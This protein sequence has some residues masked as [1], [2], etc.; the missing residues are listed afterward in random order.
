MWLALQSNKTYSSKNVKF[1]VKKKIL[2]AQFLFFFIKV[3]TMQGMEKNLP[4]FKKYNFII[5][6]TNITKN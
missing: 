3:K 2:I 5:K 1:I 6:Y 4:T